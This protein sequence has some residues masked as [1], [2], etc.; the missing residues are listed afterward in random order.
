MRRSTD[1]ILV[2]HAGTLPRPLDLQQLM[3]A[4]PAKAAQFEAQLPEAIKQVVHRQAEIGVDV[5]NDGE[6]GKVGGFAGYIRDRMR[7]ISQHP[8]KPGQEPRN[9]NKRDALEFPGAY[10]AYL[11]AN[12]RRRTGAA[13][14]GHGANASAPYFCTAP[15]EYIG[16]ANVHTDIDRLA[17]AVKGLDVEAYLPAV[18]PGRVEHWLWNEHYPTDEA[19]LFAIA[20][21]MHEE[22][23]AITDAGIVVQIDDPGLPDGWQ[24]YPDMSLADY[25]VY[26]ELRVDAINHALRGVPE[27]LVRLHICWGSSHMPHK[28][29][30]ELEDI[31]DIV[32]KVRAECVSVEAANPR[33]QHD[34]HVWE[35]VK[36]PAGRSYMPGVVGHSTDIIEHPRLI[37]DRLIAYAKL[38][39][40]ENVIAGTDCGLGGRVGHAE[41]A[42]AK[43]EAMV[44]GARL[45]TRELW[46][47]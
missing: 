40:R 5:V 25:R 24:M 34:I 20:D 10:T 8:L 27:S 1:H 43:L 26:A 2:S 46:G 18:A 12:Q 23:K 35:T 31:V 4:G 9:A 22:Y 42:W 13:A 47:K 11:E 21:V 7:G 17:A 29:D 37:A 19:F 6:I 30:I 44:E 41:I 33:H 15:L 28:N 14:P 45:A 36:L 16:A 32:L 38:M 3:L 39:G